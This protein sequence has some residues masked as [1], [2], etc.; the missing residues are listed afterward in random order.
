MGIGKS[1]WKEAKEKAKA[2]G[3][4]IRQK[5]EGPSPYNTFMSKSFKR[6]PVKEANEIKPAGV[7]KSPVN[8]NAF[9]GAMAKT[10]GDYKAA[11]AML[12]ASPAN[13]G[14]ED[15]K[16]LRSRRDSAA[17]YKNYG[18][19]SPANIKRMCGK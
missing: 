7:V 12:G 16:I 9:T 19:G 18:V 3:K 13:Y 10:G 1:S 14:A 8:G 11:K 6:V 4:K 2:A 15:F 17:N 5:G